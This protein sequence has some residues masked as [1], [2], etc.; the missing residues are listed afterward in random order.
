MR[1]KWIFLLSADLIF[2]YLWK[3]KVKMEDKQCPTILI[4][5]CLNQSRMYYLNMRRIF[6]ENPLT[7]PGNSTKNPKNVGEALPGKKLP[8]GLPGQPSRKNT[9]KKT[10]NGFLK[11]KYLNYKEV[12]YG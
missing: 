10:V 7:M 9:L 4:K 11:I 1:F 2:Y 5:I 6:I 3:D 12:N 8:T